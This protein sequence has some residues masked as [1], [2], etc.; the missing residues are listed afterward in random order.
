[1]YY[2]VILIFVLLIGCGRG[3]LVS[4]NKAVSALETYGF[5]EIEIIKR[6]W[7]AVQFLGGSEEDCVR[8]TAMA[9]NPAGKRVRVYVYSGWPFK[10]ATVRNP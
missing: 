4:E 5:S 8:F 6:Q 9:T 2:I 10:G 1:M 7:F 3:C